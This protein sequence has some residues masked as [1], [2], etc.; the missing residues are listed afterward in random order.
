LFEYLSRFDAAP[1]LFVGSEVSR[2][3]LGLPGRSDLLRHFAKTTGKSF[4]ADFRSVSPDLALV[5]TNV[6]AAF[7]KLWRTSETYAANRSA[8]GGLVTDTESALKIEIARFVRERDSTEPGDPVLR[9]ELAA[10]RDAVIDGV[11]TTS[12]DSLLERAFPDFRVYVGQDAAIRADVMGV[13]ELY[14]IHGSATEP[15]SLV[16]TRRDFRKLHA[17]TPYFAARVLTAFTEHPVV[18]LGCSPTD[19]DVVAMMSSIAACLEDQALH[20]LKDRLIFVELDAKSRARRLVSATLDLP[21]GLS[22]PVL[23]ARVGHFQAVL[24]A[25]GARHRPLAAPQLRRMKERVHQL[26]LASDAQHVYV[27]GIDEETIDETDVVLGVGMTTQLRTTQYRGMRRV[28]LL[29][30]LVLSDAD[31]DPTAVLNE[32]LPFV[33]RYS[34]YAPAFKYLRGARLLDN[35]G[36][37]RGDARTVLN[38]RVHE[39]VSQATVTGCTSMCR[40]PPCGVCLIRPM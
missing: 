13:G 17:R 25:L 1:F 30:D 11:I 29:R 19:N 16:L 8:D 23:T 39:Y 2:R 37:L 10:L 9:A 20:T 24:G 6:A 28:D 22:L 31:L 5:A 35:A 27:Q 14:K 38:D 36:E 18:F 3:Y 32:V 40:R 33:L 12:W 15:N 26:V 34:R 7:H 21:G 4:A